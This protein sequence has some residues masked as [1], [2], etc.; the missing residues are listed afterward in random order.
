MLLG[1][2]IPDVDKFIIAGGQVH[3][4]WRE[5]AMANPVVM[6]LQGILQP[7]INGRPDFD[8]FVISA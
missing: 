1:G 2:H 7:S 8:E 5:L 4:S 3:G 6:F